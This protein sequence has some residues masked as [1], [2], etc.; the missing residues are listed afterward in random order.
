M[1]EVLSEVEKNEIRA[2]FRTVDRL[3][4]EEPHIIE[5][6]DDIY[7]NHSGISSYWDAI[8]I[9]RRMYGA[10]NVGIVQYLKTHMDDLKMFAPYAENNG[11]Q[12]E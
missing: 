5:L 2:Y 7:E 11:G 3:V 10:I 4:R 1:K 8:R 6:A 12:N 9:A